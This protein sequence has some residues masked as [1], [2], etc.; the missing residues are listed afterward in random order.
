MHGIFIRQLILAALIAGCGFSQAARAQAPTATDPVEIVF[1][2]SIRDSKNRADF[3][4]YLKHFPNGAFAGLARN[5]IQALEA[6]PVAAPKPPSPPPPA[7]PENKAMALLPG[8]WLSLDPANQFQMAVSWNAANRRF[9]GILTAN[10][11]GSARVGFTVG[12]LIWVGTPT[13]NPDLVN[14]QQ[15]WRTLFFGMSSPSWLGGT[16]NL[17]N[18]NRNELVTNY[19]RFR[20]IQ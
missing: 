15:M 8:V 18:S 5:R 12:E 4:E 20:R 17:N 9:E 2:E 13:T 14:E 1:W 10:G 11:R 7:Q 3:E 16:I 6:P 19:A